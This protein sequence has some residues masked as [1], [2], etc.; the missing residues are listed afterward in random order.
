MDDDLDQ[1]GFLL[2]DDCDDN[3]SNINP[4]AEEIPNNGIDEDCDDMDLVSSIH[5]IGNSQINIYPNP[6]IDEIN[7]DI[8]GE[9][10]Y[11]A[12]LFDLNGK[13]LVSKENS[14]KIKVITLNNGT[15]FLEIKDLKTGQKNSRESN[16]WKIE[17]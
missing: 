2:V 1:D 14:K 9:L 7:I 12:N 5:D 13:L 8:T 4:V 16:N 11:Q 15:Y 3:N 17:T 6:T 10:S